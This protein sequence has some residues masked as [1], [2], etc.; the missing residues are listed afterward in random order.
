[1]STPH[2]ALFLGHGSPMHAIEPSAYSD[3]WSRLGREL[4]KPRAI[5]AVSAHW[6]TRGTAVTA[7][8]RPRTIHDFHGFPPA[9]YEIQYPAPGDPALAARLAQLLSP[10][11]VSLDSS[12]GLDH[13][14]WAVLRFLYPAADIPVVQLSLD[15]TASPQAHF[16]LARRLAP[17]RDA[18][19]LVLG[20]G[21]VVHNLRA[22]RPPGAPAWP[23]AERFDAAV[24]RA[25]L[26]DSSDRLIDYA[27]LDDAAALS[28][29]TS[30]HYLPLLYVLALRRAGEPVGF[31]VEGLELG[32]ISMLSVQVGGTQAG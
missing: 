9:L 28:V 22:M 29:P 25:A 7:Q 16:A 17:L 30:E 2:P 21:N 24:R 15:G 20:S 10:A 23:W 26:A 32:S 5:V 6:Y 8:Q 31:P 1:M 3:A 11:P 14:T 18:G 27:T 13:G 4:P 19:V 12:W